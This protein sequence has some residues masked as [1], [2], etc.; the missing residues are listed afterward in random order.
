MRKLL[1]YL[2][3]R[4]I[5]W[6]SEKFASRPDKEKIYDAL[7][8]LYNSIIKEP[9]K[10]GEVFSFEDFDGK[11]IIFSDQHKGNRNGADDFAV[12]EASYLAAL[13]YYSQNN[14]CLVGLGDSEE[15]WENM[16][17]QVKKA[18]RDTFDIERKFLSRGAFIKIFGN[19]DLYWA[20]DPLASLELENI[21]KQKIKVHE[22]AI[23]TT[24]INGKPLQILC[25]HGHQGDANSD[26]NWFT[27]FLIARIWAPLQAYLLINPNE[28]SNN[29]YKKTVH[30]EIMYEWS[31]TQKNLLLITGHTHQPV[32]ESLTHIERLHRQRKLAETNKDE[33]LLAK[34]NDEVKTY[35]K[36]FDTL[37]E[38]YSQIKPTY[39]NTGC[40]CF[41]DGDITG[42]E[43]ENGFIRLIKWQH[44]TDKPS[45]IVLEEK[46]LTEL[47]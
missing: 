4:P 35:Q 44:K 7:T 31:A 21:Y 15:L 41:S 28:P 30:N 40:C 34:I 13:E 16:F 36:R 5:L 18:Y 45:R 19:H 11:F 25:T 14:F 42:I 6:L 38:D 37:N 3:R 24:T 20:N 9:G 26:G 47:M 43:I 12:A 2:L 29:I 1:Q 17:W 32:F 23:L 22:G 27:K 8:K 46:L 10:K 39:F 33:K